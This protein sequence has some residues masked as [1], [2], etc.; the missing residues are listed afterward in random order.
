MVVLPLRE[1]SRSAF[2][3]LQARAGPHGRVCRDRRQRS[4]GC[5][6][7]PRQRPVSRNAGR[8]GLLG[9]ARRGMSVREYEIE[10]VSEEGSG[11]IAGDPYVYF[12][13]QNSSL[14]PGLSLSR[15]GVDLRLPH[16]RRILALLA[17][18]SRLDLRQGGPRWC[19]REDKS[20]RE[21]IIYVDPGLGST[22]RSSNGPSVGQP[23]LGDAHR[24]ASHDPEP[25]HRHRRAGARGRSNQV[26]FR[27]VSRSRRRVSSPGRR[28]LKA[29]GDSLSERRAAARSTRRTFALSVRQPL[30]VKSPFGPARPPTSEVGIRVGK[31]FTA[32]G[33][34]G[35]YTW[36]LVSGNCPQASSSTRHRGTIAGTPK[37][38]GAFAFGVTA[39]D[40]EGARHHVRCCIDGCAATRDQD[41]P[42]EAREGRKPVPDELAT[43]G[44][45]Q[46]AKWSVINGTLPPGLKL[47]QTT[48]TISGTPRQSGAF[49]MT[50]AARTRSAR[51]RRRRS[52]CASR[53]ESLTRRQS[54]R[55]ARTSRARRRRK[56]VRLTTS[57]DLATT[58]RARAGTYA[59]L[60][61]VTL[62]TLMY[63]I[64]LTRIFSVTM[65]YHF[66]FVAISVALFGLTVGAL[67]VL[68]LS[69]R[70]RDRDIGDRLWV[71]AAAVRH[72][73][74]GLLRHAAR[75]PI[76]P[77]AERGE[78]RG[79]SWSPALSS[80]SR[81]C[82]AAVVV[83]LALTRFP[84]AD[85]P[86]LRGGPR[87]RGA[88]LR[89][90]S[91]PLSP[92]RRPEPR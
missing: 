36:A 79:R 80:R 3:E 54:G 37:T 48:G 6:L 52:S 27:R 62:S 69:A 4:I 51:S 11:C 57:G 33:G 77:G 23:Y 64:V 68:P 86:P 31:T 91:W 82:A 47:S 13:I 76:R 46:P 7:R 8:S 34:S 74:R 65:W 58:G 9:N 1:P 39:T 40:S 2:V 42:L 16:E 35:P 66:A 15:D 41:P 28:P 81:S 22:T 56:G 19:H 10:I 73:A 72:V 61:L 90:S 25:A 24:Q 29:A 30:S 45:V 50:L 71:F 20:E 18:G 89:R 43:I 14:P 92:A 26:R 75:D 55:C 84:S 5:G 83:C 67:L 44:G 59:G 60:F 63:E 53:A 21:F 12:E 78:R 70:F 49:R 85:E 17:L 32:T 38:A 87:R 88:R